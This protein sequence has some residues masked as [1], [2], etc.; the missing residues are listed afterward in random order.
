MKQSS[1]RQFAFP[2][3]AA[4]IWGSAFVAQDIA[5]AYVDPFTFNTLRSVI[6]APLLALLLLVMNIYRKKRSHPGDA[7]S[8]SPEARARSRRYLLLGGLL[9]GTAL[10][11]A[12]NLQQ[13]GI[14]DATAGKAGFIT[15]LYI[16]IVPLIG[17]FLGKKISLFISGSVLLAAGGLY[18]LCVTDG[19]ALEASD[20][21]LI[22]CALFFS[23][24]ILLVDYFTAYVDGIA[25]S[26]MQFVVSSALSGICMLIFGNP[27][28]EGISQCIP[29]ILYVAVFSSGVAYTLQILAQ[30][31]SNPTIV[32][33]LLSLEALFAAIAGA[34]ISKE[35][36]SGREYIGC[37]L[38]LAAVVLAQL[39]TDLLKSKGK[40]RGDSPADGSH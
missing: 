23:I 22:L 5:S 34:I 18:F 15:A 11:L 31:G 1:I 2:L 21:F 30:K 20:I 14:A 9:C 19:L 38:M 28:L 13:F 29:Q 12:S 26:C 33:L 4:V 27:T 16:V 6:A 37:L 39:P 35:L 36:L 7:P 17:L 10:T 3:A 25:L 32:S 24:H 40:G 8:P